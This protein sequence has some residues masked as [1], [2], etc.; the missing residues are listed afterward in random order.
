M[1][2]NKSPNPLLSS[3]E[4][5]PFNK[6]L[7]YFIACA[8]EGNILKASQKLDVQQSGLS[9]IIMRLESDIGQKLFS[10]SSQGVQMTSFGQTFY[11][12][13]K[14]TKNFWRD[15]SAR[16][17]KQKLIIGAHSSIA[18]SYFPLIIPKLLIKYPDMTI[19]TDLAS[20]LDVT[21]KVAELQI[22]IGLVI[23]PVKN[24]DLVAQTLSNSWIGVWGSKT[25]NSKVLYFNPEMFMNQ[26]MIKKFSDHKKVPIQDYEVIANILKESDAVGLLPNTV[27][28][29]HGLNSISESLLSV[30]LCMIWHRDQ[31]KSEPIRFLYNALKK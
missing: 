14:Q 12:S 7:E 31:S 22:D 30:N 16:E 23:N 28:T 21:R 18:N 15:I 5:S 25:K 8:E 19:D 10:R 4:M 13:L 1:K 26:R 11:Q 27:G 20:S 9:K 24:A 29:R 2:N 6:D 3:V 17:I